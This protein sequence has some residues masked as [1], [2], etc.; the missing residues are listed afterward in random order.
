VVK[1][2]C[3]WLSALVALAGGCAETVYAPRIVA[4]GELTLRYHGAYEMWAGG[5]QVA[6]GLGWSGLDEY[7][8]CVPEA[9]RLAA[10]AETSGHTAVALS[11]VGGILGGVAVGGLVGFIDTRHQW[12]WLGSGVATA[13]VGVTLAGSG[14]LLRNRANG[15]AIDAMNHYNDAVGSLGASC[16]DQ[17]YPPPVGPGRPEDTDSPPGAPP[18]GLQPSQPPGSP[19]LP[20]APTP[21]RLPPP[22]LTLPPPSLMLPPVQLVVPPSPANER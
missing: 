19:P 8:G 5:K 10:A 17:S 20:S 11:L 12:I 15:Q 9:H 18:P 21:S 13:V 4:R 3:A 6:R 2:T 22:H 7:V 1:A 16:A 14:R